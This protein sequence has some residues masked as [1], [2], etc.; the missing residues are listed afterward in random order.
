MMD[1]LLT[2]GG[3]VLCSERLDGYG[4]VLWSEGIGGRSEGI[5][6]RSGRHPGAEL[7]MVPLEDPAN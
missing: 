3:G 7:P 1:N 5:G 6:G 2:V 4:L